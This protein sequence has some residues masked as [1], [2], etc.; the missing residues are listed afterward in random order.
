M[1][2][3]TLPLSQTIT[4]SRTPHPRAWRTLW[5]APYVW[6]RGTEATSEERKTVADNLMAVQCAVHQALWPVECNE[7]PV[8]WSKRVWR[9]LIAMTFPLYSSSYF[10]PLVRTAL[11]QCRAFDVTG[12]FN[13]N[14][15]PH[16]YYE[17]SPCLVF[18]SHLLFLSW[19]SFPTK[20]P[21]WKRLWSAFGISF[22]I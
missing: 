19:R 6:G 16:L 3:T 8:V 1:L 9:I 13:R 11:P 15:L 18:H 4:P 2:L 12:P 20:L 22:A 7:C 14:V 10:V 21:R 5:T 17:Q